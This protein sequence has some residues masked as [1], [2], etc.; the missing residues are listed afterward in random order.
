MTTFG[1][2]YD[3]HDFILTSQTDVFEVDDDDDKRML[4]GILRVLK[5]S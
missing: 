2:F 5:T 3:A 1:Q 4:V